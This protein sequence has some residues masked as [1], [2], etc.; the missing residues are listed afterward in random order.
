MH[1]EIG[2]YGRSR[3]AGIRPDIEN[4]PCLSRFALPTADDMFLDKIAAEKV[5]LPL[6]HFAQIARNFEPAMGQR[7][8]A[9][10]AAIAGGQPPKRID[11]SQLAPANREMP[12]VRYDKPLQRRR[13]DHWR[14]SNSNIGAATPRVVASLWM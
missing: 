14:L 10:C 6:E 8:Q 2:S 7:R 1:G 4:H 5:E 13:A 9:S 11:R 3:K 12:G